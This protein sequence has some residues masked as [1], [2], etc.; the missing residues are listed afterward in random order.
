LFG[1]K[2]WLKSGGYLYIEKTEAMT[3]VDVNSGRYA[4]KREQ[5]LNSLRTDLEAAREVCRQ[6][7]LRDIGGL[8]VVDF[9]DLEDEKNKKKVYDEM[10]KEM[11]RDRAKITVLPMTE[12][13]L[14]QIT[15]QRIRQTV[16]MSFSEACPTCAG[17]GL[18]QSKNTTLNQIER[19]IKRY[20][21]DRKGWRVELRVNPAI[22]EPLT[23]G[24]WSRIRKLE[25]QNRVLVK[26]V[27]D[28]NIM[29][30]DFKFFSP[31]LGKEITQDYQS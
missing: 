3:V 9:I 10:K 25:L 1:K 11:K 23:R 18:V 26:V 16:Q 24:T 21:T 31:K 20:S 5:E 17:T 22:A 12:F 4:A 6:L 29:S 27:P 15:R 30:D 13:G 28:P 8:I 14:V 2:V 19:W 7:R